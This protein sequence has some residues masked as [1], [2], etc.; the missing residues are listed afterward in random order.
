MGDS[1]SAHNGTGVGIVSVAEASS[2]AAK[3]YHSFSIVTSSDRPSAYF[4]TSSR[5]CIKE[6]LMGRIRAASRVGRHTCMHMSE[7][8]KPA[9][10]YI[11]SGVFINPG[12]NNFRL[13]RGGCCHT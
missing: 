4:P 8:N 5:T 3:T 1:L 13:P 6:Y 7:V 9:N 12:A 11:M 10:Y 2:K